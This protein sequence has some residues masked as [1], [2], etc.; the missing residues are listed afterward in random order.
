MYSQHPVSET[1]DLSPFFAPHAVPLFIP[2][3]RSRWREYG[4]PALLF[5]VTAVCV[6]VTGS[7]LF[8]TPSATPAWRDGLLLLAGAFSIMTAHEMGHYLACRYY[9][10]DAS[11]PHFLPAPPIFMGFAVAPLLISLIGT[12]G[13]FIRIR[14]PIPHRRALFDIGVAGPLA[15]FVVTLAVL[16]LSFTHPSI[17]PMTTNAE[18]GGLNSPPLFYIVGRHVL[19]PDTGDGM[20]AVPNQPLLLAAWFGAFLTAL[21]LMPVGQLDGGHAIYALLMRYAAR[22]SRVAMWASLALVYLS[23]AW[24]L[25]AILLRVLGRPHPPTMDDEAPVGRRRAIVGVVTLA[26]FLLCFM[27]K[28][29]EISW[30]EFLAGFYSLWPAK[31]T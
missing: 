26:V 5:V 25:W 30:T 13:A 16:W 11:L 7:I 18:A 12:F 14:G 3:T 31:L 27:P 28:P 15:G 29:I 10:V 2:P 6:C 8:E 23:P 19:L 21:N 1:Q 22:I 17:V 9:G 4:R 24:L 20:L